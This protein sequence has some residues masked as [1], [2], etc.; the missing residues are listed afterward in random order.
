M[1]HATYGADEVLTGGPV[2]AEE[3]ETLERDLGFPLPDDYRAFIARYGW[4]QAGPFAEVLIFGVDRA[5]AAEGCHRGGVMRETRALR[6]RMLAAPERGWPVV[7]SWRD[8][9]HERA[10]CGWLHPG[11]STSESS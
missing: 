9:P 3:L 4:V 10:S 1:L 2:A 6:G 8:A 11:R 5:G 7:R